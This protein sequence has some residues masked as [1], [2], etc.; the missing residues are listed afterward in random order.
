[1]SGHTVAAWRAAKAVKCVWNYG[2]D[3][4]EFTMP[5]YVWGDWV[6]GMIAHCS[7]DRFTRAT[8]F[9]RY[10][11]VIADLEKCGRGE[12]GWYSFYPVAEEAA[13]K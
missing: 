5:K 11:Q 9:E 8:I 2:N 12:H 6:L 4:H 1:M 3:H 7:P 13:A 10:G